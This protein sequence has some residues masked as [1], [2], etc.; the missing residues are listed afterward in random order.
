MADSPKTA[1]VDFVR[2]VHEVHDLFFPGAQPAVIVVENLSKRFGGT[3]AVSDLSFEVRPG[4]VTGFLGPNG[5]G[6]TTTMRVIMGLETADV[7]TGHHRRGAPTAICPSRS[8]RSGRCSDAR[9]AHPG[10]DAR[11]HLAALAAANRLARR[12]GRRGA[13]PRRARGRRRTGGPATFS[14]GMGQRLGI[15][16]ALL[17]DPAVLLFDEPTN[18]LD[19][20]GIV[21][22][23]NLM[24][25]LAA[26]GRAVLVSSHLMSEMA[27]TADHLVVIGRGRLIA[28][29]PLEA[30]V[31]RTSTE[32]V[33]VRT[34]APDRLAAVLAGLG[35]YTPAAT[36]RSRWS[37]WS[38]P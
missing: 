31:A 14:L 27:L 12:P 20:E 9:A 35:A 10:R 38:R 6:K 1:A 23:R 36:E 8:R 30:F 17:G 7:G 18:G 24:G 32:T 22:I 4:V 37:G 26:E 19:P 5:A 33:L 34:P 11:S 29:E 25:E 3:E 21:W 13:R 28:D 2:G 16:A 15:A